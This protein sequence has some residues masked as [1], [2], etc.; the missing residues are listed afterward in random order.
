M[1]AASDHVT[2]GLV[3]IL[4]A[5]PGTAGNIGLR[6]GRIHPLPGRLVYNSSLW[7]AAD[8]FIRCWTSSA[9]RGDKAVDGITSADILSYKRAIRSLRETLQ[10]K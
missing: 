3:G 4:N 6:A 5:E 9:S 10:D 7:C 2:Q 1:P 8:T